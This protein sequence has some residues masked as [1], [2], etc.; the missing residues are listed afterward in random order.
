MSGNNEFRHALQLSPLRNSSTATTTGDLVAEQLLH[1]GIDPG[2]AG[3]Q[4]L[5]R[6]VS[7]ISHPVR[8]DACQATLQALGVA[9]VIE[10]SPAGTLA[11][12]A[13]RTMPGVRIV[14]LKTPADLDAARALLADEAQP[15]GLDPSGVPA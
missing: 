2:S 1:F 15:S 6:L 5:A 4:A 8:W 14:T 3:G 9:T 10:L 7:Q 11:G 13:K 12:L